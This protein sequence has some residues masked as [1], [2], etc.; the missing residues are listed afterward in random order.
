MI[1]FDGKKQ[2]IIKLDADID[3]KAKNPAPMPAKTAQPGSSDPSLSRTYAQNGEVR[4]GPSDLVDPASVIAQNKQIY[5]R[6]AD[7]NRKVGEEKDLRK[8]KTVNKA[9]APQADLKAAEEAEED[10]IERELM[11]AAANEIEFEQRV[12]KNFQES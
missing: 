7:R 5:D 9:Q 10:L 6:G 8:S 2:Q 12:Q 1:L 4:H 11:K 3:L